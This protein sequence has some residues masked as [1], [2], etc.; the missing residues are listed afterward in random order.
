MIWPRN[1]GV[2]VYKS[3]KTIYKQRKRVGHTVSVLRT[4]LRD[5]PCC[6]RQILEWA[7][8]TTKMP[9]LPF[10]FA[11]CFLHFVSPILLNCLVDITALFI[12]CYDFVLHAL[13]LVEYLKE[14]KA[15]IATFFFCICFI[16]SVCILQTTKHN[17]IIRIFSCVFHFT[18]IIPRRVGERA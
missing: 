2:Y 8:I 18:N 16:F 12:Y 3:R 10:M 7:Q 15:I 11:L 13:S 17:N 6:C 5:R 9:F 14:P 1:H 4:S